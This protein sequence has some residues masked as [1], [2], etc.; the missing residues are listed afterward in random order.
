MENDSSMTS[1]S[2]KYFGF[3]LLANIC[4][5]TSH[6]TAKPKK[7]GHTAKG[8]KSSFEQTVRSKFDCNKDWASPVGGNGFFTK[9][10]TYY[11]FAQLSKQATSN[12]IEGS[13]RK[14]GV[15]KVSLATMKPKLLMTLDLPKTESIVPHSDPPTALTAIVF[16]GFS[17]LCLRGPARYISFPIE[18]GKKASD[19]LR[20]I[21]G[22]GKL[23]TI[24]TNGL[25]NVFDFSRGSALKFD[26][27]SYQVRTIFL[28]TRPDEILLYLDPDRRRYYTW[29]PKVENDKRGLAAYEGQGIRAGGM[30]FAEGDKLIHQKNLFGVAHYKTKDQGIDIIELG[31]WTG[32]SDKKVYTI[33]IPKSY[34]LDQTHLKVNFS[35]KIATIAA[36]SQ[37]QR[38][39]TKTTIIYDYEKSWKLS[40]FDT[41]VNQYVAFET[42]SPNGNYVVIE[43][44]SKI[45]ENTELLAIYSVASRKWKKVYLS[46]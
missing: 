6:T 43:S 10:L 14:Y 44:K 31:R 40:K 32:R 42:I 18:T 17:N 36:N 24:E 2:V 37:R 46:E 41:P 21:Q 33:H 12:S 13:Q 3:F 19:K 34:T 4:L 25:W 30:L 23:Q 38:K 11:H 28:T 7:A 27:N 45:T 1:L 15:Y 20:V 26:F 9:D 8:K 22:K 39:K 29:Q 35:R 16:S 5:F